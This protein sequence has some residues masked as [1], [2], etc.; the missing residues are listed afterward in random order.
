MLTN[1]LAALTLLT[2]AAPSDD[3]VRRHRDEPYLAIRTGL[4]ECGLDRIGVGLGVEE[5]DGSDCRLGMADCR[6][7]EKGAALVE[8]LLEDVR[9]IVPEDVES[10]EADRREGRRTLDVEL[11]TR[12][13]E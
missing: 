2:A 6:L 4:L 11:R 10:D 12:N 3:G 9:A 1:V 5:L 8:G 7:V 13:F